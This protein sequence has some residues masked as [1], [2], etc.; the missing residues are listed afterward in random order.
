MTYTLKGFGPLISLL[1]YQ[2]GFAPTGSYVMAFFDGNTLEAC[3]RFDADDV[4]SHPDDLADFCAEMCAAR[5][6]NNAILIEYELDNDIGKNLDIPFAQLCRGKGISLHHRLEVR[7]DSWRIR[8]CETGCC[9]MNWQA[10]EH[11]WDVAPVAE[12]VARGIAPLASRNAAVEVLTLRDQAGITLVTEILAQL[13]AAGVRQI[14]SEGHS[15]CAWCEFVGAAQVDEHVLARVLVRLDDILQRDGAICSLIPEL[16]LD[17]EPLF[18]TWLTSKD[19]CFDARACHIDDEAQCL[20]QLL[21]ALPSIPDSHRVTWLCFIALARWRSGDQSGAAMAAYR[22]IDEDA[23]HSLAR[24]CSMILEL[25]RPYRDFCS[26]SD[27][28]AS[29]L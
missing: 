1:P 10:V 17:T 28:T 7:G 12:M 18:G 24:L 27:R 22:A 8:T 29:S 11:P 20:R 21:E 25:R 23:S 4:V 3:L 16:A 19:G 2:F 14:R 26:A 13:D 6:I 15:A 9:D 5:T